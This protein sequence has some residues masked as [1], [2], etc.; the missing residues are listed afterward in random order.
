M[1][2]NQIPADYQRFILPTAQDILAYDCLSCR[3]RFPT[4]ELLHTCPKCGGLTSLVITN[5][6]RLTERPGEFWR[7]LFDYRRLINNQA[8]KGVFNFQEFLAPSIGEEDIVYLGE[9]HT[10]LVLAPEKV[11][12]ILKRPFYVKLE[13]LNPTCSFK[14]R[15]MA[16]ALSFVK[17]M[18]RKKNLTHLIAVCASTGD[19]SAAAALYA[20]ALGDSVKTAVLLPK[21]YVTDQQLSQPLL[22]GAKVFE[23]PGVFD[24]CMKVVEELSDKYQVAL[25]NSKNPWRVLGQESYSYEL[26]QDLDWDLENK[27]LFVPV[28]NAGNMT[29][30][31]SGLLKL[32][33]CEVITNFPRVVAVQ[34]HHANPVY[35]YYNTP[36]NERRYHPVSVKLSVA[37]AAMIGDPVSMPRLTRLVREFTELGGIFNAVEVTESEI[38]ES[39]LIANQNGLPICTQGGVS[40]AGVKRAVESGI[41]EAKEIAIINSTAHPLKFME[42]VERYYE[43]DLREYGITRNPHYT[44]NPIE[45]SF[46]SVRLP[47]KERP[48]NEIDEKKYATAAAR[49]I[50]EF[51]QL[52]T[53]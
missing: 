18:M 42:F 16:V 51:L 20:G 14:D 25:L 38:M 31:V 3:S 40:L 33:K 21:G 4:D 5:Q 43:D 39:M 12:G 6:R 41:L 32:H 22:S 35:R 23:L 28:G 2:I 34:S 10:P 11:A 44:N 1:Q 15:G 7:D 27:A 36:P 47:S 9:G 49:K 46:G 37:Q 52:D 19:T 53:R 45:L 29:A 30:I 8:L 17:Q 26:A 24:D 48:L 13:G 50:A